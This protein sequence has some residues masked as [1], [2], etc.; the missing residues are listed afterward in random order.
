MNNPGDMELIPGELY[1]HVSHSVPRTRQQRRFISLLGRYRYEPFHNDFG[2]PNL[3]QVYRTCELIH[4]KVQVRRQYPVCVYMS[5]QDPQHLANA[6]FLVC[7]YL[8]LVRGFTPKQAYA[9]I[10]KAN[11]NLT[12]F[13]DAGWG[14]S[15]FDST[16]YHCL[17]GVYKAKKLGWINL[18]AFDPDYYEHWEQVANGDLNWIVPGRILAMCSPID[19][20]FARANSLSDVYH[21]PEFYSEYFKANNVS[22]IIRLN[23]KEYDRSAFLKNGIRHVDSYFVDN[24]TPP[25]NIRDNFLRLADNCVG[26]LAVHCKSGVGRT[27]TLIACYLM[28]K[29]R[30][31]AAESI[32]YIRVMRPG[33]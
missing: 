6:T 19:D 27:G 16:V 30:F 21:T 25:S 1:F 22:T 28:R 15:V 13:R 31:T 33:R 2:P 32:G 23:K 29:Y 7:A 17:C 5:N 11:L 24:T 9:P 12:P 10:A 26:A 4:K 8:V 3:A 14:D 18:D 20:A